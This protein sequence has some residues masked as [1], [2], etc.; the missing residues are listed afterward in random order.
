[1]TKINSNKSRRNSKSND[2]PLY[3]HKASGQWTKKVRQKIHYFGKDKQA[4]LERWLVQ[5][6]A[7]LAG[8]VP[9]KVGESR[10]TVGKLVNLFLEYKEQFLQTGEL[11]QRSF[12]DYVTHGRMLA[13]HFGQHTSVDG[14]TPACFLKFRS[15]LAKNVN[16]VTLKSRIV[17][18]RAFFNFAA[19]NDLLESPLP[20][21]MGTGFVIPTRGAITKLMSEREK[22]FSASQ[23]KS[24]IDHANTNIRAMILLGINCGFGNQDVAMLRFDHLDLDSGWINFPRPKTGAKRR[25]PLWPETVS[26]LRESIENRR[27]PVDPSHSEHV[28]ITSQG[29]IYE[30]SI[31]DKPISKEFRKLRA[32]VGLETGGFYWLRHTFQ[33]IGDESRDFVAVSSI[34]GH[35]NSSISDHYRERISDERLVDVVKCVRQWLNADDECSGSSAREIVR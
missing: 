27:L 5:K 13:Q 2:F 35:A 22:L 31:Q 4:A 15:S 18:I 29:G 33:T 30:S 23:I 32:K 8:R 20:R 14:L 9:P 16:L 12:D 26:A 6:D 21:I 3:L 10:L 34:M 25:C 7:I 19:K 28:F 1:M 11:G 24:L 17:K